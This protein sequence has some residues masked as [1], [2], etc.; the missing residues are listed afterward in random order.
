ME[1]QV[2]RLSIYYSHLFLG[3]VIFKCIKNCD[4]YKIEKIEIRLQNDEFEEGEV[5]R[6]GEYFFNQ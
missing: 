3:W 1:I 5:G 4:K 6:G 2:S